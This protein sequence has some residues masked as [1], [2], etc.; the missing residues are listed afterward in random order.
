MSLARR[1][2]LLATSAALVACSAEA[3]YTVLQDQQKDVCRKLLNFDDQSNCIK[4][5]SKPYDAY[6]A[7]EQAARNGGRQASSP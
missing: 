1:L 4:R 2:A 7:D 6:K 3:Y 5:I